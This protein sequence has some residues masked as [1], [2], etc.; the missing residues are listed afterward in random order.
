MYGIICANFGCRDNLGSLCKSAFHSH[1]FQQG[2]ND[3]YPVISL[4]DLNNSLVDDSTMFDEDPLRF[5]EVRDGDYLMT[6]F[7]CD[8]CHFVNIQ[9]RLPQALD[10]QDKLLLLTIQRVVLD[11]LWAREHSTVTKNRKE[12]ERFFKRQAMLG[13]SWNIM[14]RRG[15]FRQADDWG[16]HVACAIVLQSLEPGGNAPHVQYDMV[17]KMRSFY[18]NYAHTCPGGTG[19]NFM[20]TEGAGARVSN[21]VSNSDWFQKFMR[22][23]HRRMGDVWLPNQ[24]I[25]QYEMFACMDVLESKWE[26][27]HGT[28]IDLYELKR[29]A[30]PACIVLAGYFGSL[31]GEEINRVDLG[32][33]LKYW[34]ESTEHEHHPH[35][36]LVLSG[37][38]KV[39]TGIKYF[40]QPLAMQTDSGQ[41]IGVW[42]SRFLEI[43]KEEGALLGPL[44]V[45]DKGKRMSGAEIDLLFHSLLSEVQRC[46]AKVLPESVDVKNKF[47]TYQSFR[48]GSTSEAQNA[49]M[50]HQVIEANNR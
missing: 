37:T 19:A 36:A 13:V 6:P 9:G 43:R 4:R 5:K 33:M 3:E 35:V 16:V 44:F 17:R 34:E 47:S 31:R 21:S 41:D 49:G 1:C 20:S 32:A 22:G 18:S 30:T 46:F 27:A 26:E 39:V 10:K 2:E 25:S 8:I 24:A 14:T 11:S 40:C 45:G 28:L 23:M 50:P 12:G 29:T 48:R 7:Q 38:F 42:F 15:P